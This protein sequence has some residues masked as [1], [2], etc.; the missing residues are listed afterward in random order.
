[1]LDEPSLGLSPLF[2]EKIFEIIAD[3][4][5]EGVTII[6]V[7]QNAVMASPWPT[8]ATSSERKDCLHRYRG[9]SSEKRGYHLPVP[10]QPDQ[11]GSPVSAI[12][13]RRVHRWND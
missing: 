10:G 6:L 5:K 13:N 8:G 9:Q 7:E 4:Q 3:I 1:M 2:T 11:A 12:W